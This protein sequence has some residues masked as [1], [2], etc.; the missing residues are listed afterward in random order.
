MPLKNT[1]AV[2]D[3]IALLSAVG[4]AG[5]VAAQDQTTALKVA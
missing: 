2:F 4:L 3:L 1:V 5:N